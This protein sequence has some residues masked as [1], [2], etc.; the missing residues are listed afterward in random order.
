MYSSRV[1]Y[2][3]TIV[4][5]VLLD[6]YEEESGLEPFQ[7]DRDISDGVQ[8]YLSIQVLYQVSVQT[9]RKKRRTVG[10]MGAVSQTVRTLYDAQLVSF[11]GFDFAA[12]YL[13]GCEIKSGGR[14]ANEGSYVTQ[15]ATICSMY[16]PIKP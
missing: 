7:S 5:W 10:I 9:A 15:E 12:I 11:P 14:P 1:S 6:A 3:L 13:H 4:S 2:R 8:H 16:F